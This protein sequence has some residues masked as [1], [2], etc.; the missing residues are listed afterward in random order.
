MV[1]FLAPMR[2]RWIIFFP[3]MYGNS[4]FYTL[5]EFILNKEPQNL[6]L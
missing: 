5:I 6:V 1:V 4:L 2:A 3:F